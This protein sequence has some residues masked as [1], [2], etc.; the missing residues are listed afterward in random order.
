MLMNFDLKK[1]PFSRYGSYFSISYL[2]AKGSLE[3]GIYLRNIRGG[4]NDNGAVFKLDVLQDGETVPFTTTGH[5]TYLQLQTETGNVKFVMSEAGNV[6]VYG[7][8]A[9]LRMTMVTQAYDNAFPHKEDSWQVNIFSKKIR[10]MLTPLQGSLKVDAP[11]DVN[12]CT[13][14]IADFV[15]DDSTQEM[16]AV[17]EEFI[18]SYEKQTHYAD[19]E[20]CHS[21]VAKEFEEWQDNVLSV[22]SEFDKGRQLASYITWSC[23]VNPEDNLTRPAMYMSKNWMTNIWSWDHCFNA[24]ALVEKNPELAWDQYMIFFDKQDPSGQLPDYMNNQYAY[25]NCSKPPIHGW[26][27]SWMLK[28]T[29]QISK[30]QLSEVYGPLTKW[31]NW[32]LNHRDDNDN[33]FSE[34]HHGNDSGW[35]NSTIFAE[36]VSVESPDLC[37]FLVLQ[38]ETLAEVAELLDLKE[39]AIKWQRLADKLLKD[40]IEHFWI[41]DRFVAYHLNQEVETGDSLL[42]FMPIILGDRL[43]TEIRSKLVEGLKDETRFLTENGLATESTSSPYYIPDGYWR[44]PIWAP[45][46]MLLIDGLANAG[47]KDFSQNLARRYCAMANENGMAENFDAKTGKGLR[48]LAFTWT[49]SVFLILG[50]EYI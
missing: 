41:G 1:I 8:N 21:K 20:E 30:K 49:S 19:F 44:G 28:R 48:D 39:E 42:L 13:H 27:L 4:D 3:E 50:N 32:Y 37:A 6:H 15:P 34:Y 10:Y 31:T 35:D 7:K 5:P 45:S 18:T 16:T 25:W 14:V 38:M 9:G 11:W 17:I 2:S 47:E 29:D 26:T 24:M 46:T 43:P 40:M 22:P 23:I 33:G 36:G 12:R